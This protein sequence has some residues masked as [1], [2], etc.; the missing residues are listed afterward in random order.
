MKTALKAALLSGLV[1]PGLGHIYLRHYAR[2]I[3]LMLM[4]LSG[5]GYA[6]GTAMTKALNCLQKMQDAGTVDLSA[7][8]S[9]AASSTA[10]ATASP[11]YTII[12]ILVACCWLF[13]IVDAYRI[14][15]RADQPGG[16]P[17]EKKTPLH[18]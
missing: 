7:L 4:V 8:S 17:A 12:L 3:I 1:L 16:T 9:L 11:L 14:G 10:N 18:I 2:G 15:K 6:V 5:S 13:S